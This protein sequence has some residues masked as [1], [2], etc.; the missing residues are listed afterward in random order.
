MD[1]LSTVLSNHCVKRCWVCVCVYV[2]VCVC[3]CVC[4]LG[5]GLCVCLS[6]HPL[7]CVIEEEFVSACS[8]RKRHDVQALLPLC[9]F[10]A[11]SLCML[12]LIT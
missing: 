4:V 7:Q 5:C 8:N 10:L 9:V 6:V 12:A 3:V 11:F 1:D 2:C